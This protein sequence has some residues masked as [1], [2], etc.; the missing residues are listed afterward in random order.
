VPQ[1]KIIDILSGWLL[2][3]GFKQKPG[4]WKNKHLIFE[5][6][7]EVWVIEAATSE[8]SEIDGAIGRLLRKLYQKTGNKFFLAVPSTDHIEDYVF[9]LGIGVIVAGNDSVTVIDSTKPSR[10]IHGFRGE[11]SKKER[12]RIRCSELTKRHFYALVEQ[13]N[14]KTLEDALIYLLRKGGI[15]ITSEYKGLIVK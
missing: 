11:Q 12:I 4:N 5:R 2:E 8:E 1:K 13:G 14:F 9:E 10:Y 7:R 3:R 15:G 6:D